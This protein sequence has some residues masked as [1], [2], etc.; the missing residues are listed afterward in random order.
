MLSVICLGGSIGVFCISPNPGGQT[1]VYNP[2]GPPLI[3]PLPALPLGYLFNVTIGGVLTFCGFNTL[4]S[5]IASF[6]SVKLTRRGRLSHPPV[7]QILGLSWLVVFT[8]AGG[9]L[10]QITTVLAAGLMVGLWWVDHALGL[11]FYVLFIGGESTLAWRLIPMTVSDLTQAV[12]CSF[13]V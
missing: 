13:Y 5:K 7:P 11:R 10:G 2:D 12:M 4:A 1:L 6:V 8:R 3:L 9:V